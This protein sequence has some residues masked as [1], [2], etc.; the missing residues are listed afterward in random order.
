MKD[1]L[2]IVFEDPW[3]CIANKPAGI[4]VQPDKSGDPS[5]LEAV[6]MRYPKK[7]VGLVHRIDRLTMGLVVF[8]LS[9]KSLA[10]CNTRFKKNGEERI[11]NDCRY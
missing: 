4:P 1:L 10:A 7:N 6:Q 2:D 11:L 8:A 5:L 9:T 3:L